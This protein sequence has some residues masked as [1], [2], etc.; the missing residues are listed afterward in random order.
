[1]KRS[2]ETSGKEVDNWIGTWWTPKDST[3]KQMVARSLSEDIDLM[4]RDIRT[5]LD[6]KEDDIVLDLCCGNGM[7]TRRMSQYCREIHGVDYSKI[8]LEEARR[9]DSCTNVHYY[10]GNA[11]N[12]DKLFTRSYFD[13]IYCYAAYQYINY[14]DGRK[15]IKLM[16]D[17]TKSG[18]MI[19][20]GDI[21][22]ISRRW[23]YYNNP[24][25]KCLFLIKRLRCLI[26]GMGQDS[27]GWWWDPS[28]IE[29]ACIDLNL[30]CD[31][32]NLD[33]KLPHWN[34][35]FDALVKKMSE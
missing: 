10:F 2:N 34:Y 25:R 22:D 1:M 27:M 31:I 33:E 11:L 18:G 14:D 16:A 32:L 5:K 12:I 28:L 20:M 19:L 8:L 15:L 24:I 17:V 13:K 4:S 9:D 21:P 26:S 23:N 35:R 3:P 29:K 7:I 30:D 6:I